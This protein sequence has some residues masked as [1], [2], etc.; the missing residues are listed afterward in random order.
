M[1]RS[2]GPLIGWMRASAALL[3]CVAAC[4]CAPQASAAAPPAGTAAPYEYLGWGHPQPPVRVM[5]ATGIREFTLAFILSDGTCN[6]AWDGTRQLLGGRDESA[7]RKIRAA[8]GD[9]TVSFG[10]WSGKKLGER[11]HSAQELAAA[12]QKVIDAYS[13]RAIDIDIEHTEIAKAEVRQ[14]VVEALDIVKQVD[15]STRV[16][17]T[18]G[19]SPDGPEG[20]ELDLIQR[21]AAAGLHVDSWTIMPFDFGVPESDMGAVSVQAAEGLKAELMAAYGQSARAAYRTMGISSMNGQTDE[22]DETVTLEDF[23]TMLA[24]AQAHHL[25]RFTFWAVNRDRPCRHGGGSDSC[26]GVDQKPFDFTKVIARFAG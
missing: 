18:I 10:G 16:F 20:D 21:A 12:Y 4:L 17:V 24:Y 7:I 3:S 9:V 26:S 11:C 6:P 22:Q 25:A 1:R 23:E 5:K 2:K 8:G 14:R 13:L 19:T 15:H